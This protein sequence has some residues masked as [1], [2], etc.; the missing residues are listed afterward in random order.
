MPAPTAETLLAQAVDLPD[1]ADRA[2]FLDR[3]CGGDAALRAEVEQLADLHFRAGD[4]LEPPSA[5]PA[6]TAAYPPAGG[7]ADAAVGTRVGPYRLRELIGEGGMGA[8]YVADQ[9][10][11]VRRRVALKLIRPGMG[12][13]EVVARFEQE[14]QA[15][16]LMDHP[17]IAKVL[18]AGTAADGRPYFVMELVRG[19]PI[20]DYCDRAGLPVPDR[21]RLF[22]QVC[23]AVQH[24]HQKGVIHRDLKPANVLVT[25]VDGRPAVRVIDFGVAKAVGA[26]LAADPV[27]T[28]FAQ[29]V[30]T[31]LY[32]SPEQAGLASDDVDT[33][34]DVYSLGVVLYELLTGATPFDPDTV[35]RAGLDEVRRMVREDDPPRP[36]ARV[37]TLD[38][39]A[40]ST[41]SARRGVD[42]RRLGRQLRG[43][44]DWVVMTAL[45]KD[46]TRRYD[47]A[48]AFAAD[49]ERY[50]AD[51]PVLARPPSALYRARKF[52]R[53]HRG[54]LAV[55]SLVLAL[56]A[57]LAGGLG[58]AAGE[59]ASRRARA[60]ER[61]GEALDRAEAGLADG[62]PHA[63]DL[64]AAAGQV[65]AELAGGWVSEPVRR[66]AER[67]LADRAMLAELERIRLDRADTKDT[68]F[69]AAAADPAYA[70]AFREYG[71]DV[72]VDGAGAETAAGRI[73]ERTIAAH[74]AAAVDDWA[75]S[76]R[77][78]RTGDAGGWTRLL[79]VSRAADPDPW[80]AALRQAA[81]ARDRPALQALARSPGLA[82]QPPASLVLLADLLKSDGDPAGAVSVLQ[83][84][85]RRHPDDLWVNHDLAM[86]LAVSKPPRTEEAV[87]FFRAAVALRPLSAGVRLN[88]GN[89]LGRQGRRAEAVDCYREAVRLEPGFATA[90][91]NLGNELA[92]EGRQAEAAACYREAVR[93]KPDYP[94]AHANLGLALSKLGKPAEAAAAC[95]EAVRLRPDDPTHHN[96]LGAAL[97]DLGE[98]AGAVA[99]Y[100]E[101]LRLKPD[102]ADAHHN[103]GI[104]LYRQGKLPEALAHSREA[105]RLKPDFPAAHLNL[106]AR[107]NQLGDLAGAASHF[108]EAIRLQPD[109]E[110]AH[111]NLGVVRHR[112]GKPADA[113]PCYREAVRLKPDYV[114]AH[115]GLGMALADLGKLADAVA[116]Y[117]EAVRLKPD[118]ADAHHNLGAALANQQWDSLEATAHLREAVRLRPDLARGHYN[119]GLVLVEQGE[120]AGAARHARTAAELEPTGDFLN[121]LGYVLYR[122]GDWAGAVAA[123]RRAIPAKSGGDAADFFILALAHERLGDKKQAREWYDRAV[124][125]MD[126]H[127]PGAENL[128]QVREEAAA[129][130]G[131]VAP[132]PRPAPA[133]GVGKNSGNR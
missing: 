30:G 46:R 133:A 63:S 36:S 16:A 23:R 15:L 114:D 20:T 83:A 2:A 11:P 121:A 33:R 76:R 54:G 81:A 109:Y 100:R 78:A 107:L 132:P 4:F 68:H 60:D 104:A 85:H 32:M 73:R 118:S 131:V 99:C 66:R 39:K 58:W 128:I 29:L 117:R 92:G 127:A 28:R 8:V 61:A 35:R 57:V 48:G 51:E 62:N 5:P 43:D 56:F 116:C 40:R 52:A 115:T 112:Q 17:N 126:R 67:V 75:A 10:D 65:E 130:L 111:Y 26:T 59:R 50:L 80:R 93:L 113:V 96:A 37:S 90:H 13:R 38:A 22:A 110:L 41:A 124:A 123:V 49:V 74:L 84:G 24:A 103:L 79:A 120:L 71:I 77:H 64:L 6:E 14:R 122:G 18:D 106:G 102:S 12:S 94:D 119:L 31:P 34:A 55:A 89:V 97:A 44:L 7:A 101:A 88:L 42:D 19:L 91:Y 72:D 70:R 98:L 129:R 53:R 1:P 82:E 9:E 95:R 27:Y 3:A 87:G 86:A 105:V 108:R 125:W 21:L 45:E 69:D 47:G 25:E